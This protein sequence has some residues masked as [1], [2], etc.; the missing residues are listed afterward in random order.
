MKYRLRE[1]IDR[2][3]DSLEKL[4]EALGITYQTLSKKMNEHVEFTRAEI[5]TIK[6]RYSLSAEQIDYIF[7]QV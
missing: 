3:G 4:A 2:N 1:H 5:F 7:F 6:Q